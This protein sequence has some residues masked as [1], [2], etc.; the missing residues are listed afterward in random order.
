M[1]FVNKRKAKSYVEV[2]EQTRRDCCPE[3]SGKVSPLL[4]ST[5]GDESSPDGA[6]TRSPQGGWNE[7]KKK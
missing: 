2:K 7:K 4:G 1:S 3:R 6:M 5:E